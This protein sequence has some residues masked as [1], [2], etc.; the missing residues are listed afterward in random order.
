MPTHVRAPSK[1]DM[2]KLLKKVDKNEDGQLSF[3]EFLEAAK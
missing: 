3:A 2:L 1:K